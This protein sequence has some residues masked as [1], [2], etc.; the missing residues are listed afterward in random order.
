MALEP[1]IQPGSNGQESSLS[2]QVYDMV[3]ILYELAGGN[4]VH[5]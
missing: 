5:S 1:S 2:E 3:D 4:G